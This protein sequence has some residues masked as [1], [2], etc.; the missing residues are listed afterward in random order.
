[1]STGNRDEPKSPEHGARHDVERQIG[2][3]KDVGADR[4]SS[5]R[6]SIWTI[7]RGWQSVYFVFFSLQMVLGVSLIFWYHV[8]EHVEDS[9]V[10]TLIGIV[11]DL[12]SVSVGS[13]G[14]SYT[15][16]EGARLLMILANNLEQWINKKWD[17]RDARNRAEGIAI[18][19]EEGE[20]KGR[21]VGIEEGERKGRAVE[22]AEWRAR[23]ERMMSELRAWNDRRISAES[24]GELFDEPMPG[25]DN[26]AIHS[27]ED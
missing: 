10:E 9:I 11:R 24:K 7:S 27:E 5:V 22:R 8:F 19:V 12:A 25:S 14:T 6:E 1:M 17:E 21:A 16:A 3:D 15:L 13:A 2:D 20:K 23:E 18:G 26:G 4:S